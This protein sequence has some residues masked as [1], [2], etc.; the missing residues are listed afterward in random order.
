MLKVLRKGESFSEPCALLLGGFDGLHAGH[1]SLVAAARRTGLPLGATVL[2]GNKAGGNLFTFAEREYIFEKAGFSFVLEEEF[3]E[4][5]KRI[6][7]EEYLR[8]LFS[9]IN[10]AAVF[11]GEDYRFGSGAAGTAELLQKLAP[12]PAEVLPL[13]LAGGRKVSVSEIKRWL[14]EGNVENANRLL[15][16]DYFVQGEV[17]HG[18]EVG[19]KYG[20]PTLNLSYPAG[21][22]PI[23]EG[24]YGGYAQTPLGTYSAVI[25][26][27][28]RPTFGVDEKKIEAH[29]K[30]FRG[31]LYGAVV[32]VFPEVYLRG[33]VK[34]GSEEELSLQIEKDKRYFND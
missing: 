27:G 9:R 30:D 8:S 6:P 4:E 26:F 13:T 29:L 12:R 18:R 17:E 24:V 33:V 32:R 23:A 10:A 22:F 16:V 2:C 19:R 3:T 7:A 31:D 1:M 21:K 11:C 20:F 15:A 34:F 5:F 25:N 28:S 14:Q